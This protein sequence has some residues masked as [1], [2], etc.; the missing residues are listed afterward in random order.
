M[1]LYAT[2]SRSLQGRWFKTCL[3]LSQGDAS[4]DWFVHDQ[5]LGL[6]L[7]RL[8]SRCASLV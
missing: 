5:V 3:T 1:K 6:Q 7:I 2:V 4:W 8:A